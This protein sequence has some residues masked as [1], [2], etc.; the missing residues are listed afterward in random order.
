LGGDSNG[1]YQEVFDQQF[2]SQQVN[3]EIATQFQDTESGSCCQACYCR[4]KPERP[5]EGSPAADVVAANKGSSVSD[6]PEA[7]QVSP[8]ADVLAANEGSSVSDIP[9][10]DQ[11]SSASDISAADQG[12]SASDISAAD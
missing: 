9:E 5:G 4:C 10:A 12:S 11:G 3:F 8:A 6:I 1:G 2:H 7:D